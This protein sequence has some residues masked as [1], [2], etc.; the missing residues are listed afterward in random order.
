MRIGAHTY[1][2]TQYGQ[3]Q[4]AELEGIFETVAGAG[5]GA[6]E[7]HK[8]MLDAPDWER[9]IPAAAAQTGLEIV[10]VS[11]SQPLWDVPREHAILAEMEAHAERM[12]RVGGR[13]C[14]LTCSGKRYAD[15]TAEEN[16]QAITLWRALGTLFRDRGL[17]LNYHTHGEPM[18]DIRHVIDNVP[19]EVVALGPDLD[20]L[21]AGGVD[22]LA[23]LREH[24]AR[25]SMMHLR[26]YHTGGDRTEALGEG[27]ADYGE[28]KRVLGEI[29]FDGDLVVE[30]AVPAR[31]Q[32][33]RPALELL[34]R[35]RDYLR[36][37]MG[38]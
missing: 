14:G 29:G 23:F 28:L 24:G 10:G 27:D 36:E 15:R 26:D 21:R 38:I 19:A 13:Q 31:T 32:P 17:V 37:T 9:R 16:A 7:L 8:P 35:S 33:T 20:W 2:F 12:A 3:D 11:H 1:L 5:F 25:V 6:I 22:P 30:L 4:A 18:A 34:T